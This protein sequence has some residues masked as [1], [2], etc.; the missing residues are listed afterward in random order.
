M[1]ENKERKL[2]SLLAEAAYLLANCECTHR[3]PNSIPDFLERVKAEMKA[4]LPTKLEY[5]TPTNNRPSLSQLL[6]NDPT[7][8][9]AI[10]E[11]QKEVK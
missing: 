10:K 5:R 8:V 6:S 3:A 9:A 7:F 11:Q 1:T 2:Y 4:E